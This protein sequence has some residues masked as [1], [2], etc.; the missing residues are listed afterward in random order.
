MKNLLP[1]PK[2]DFARMGCT[3]SAAAVVAAD[4]CPEGLGLLAEMFARKGPR[5]LGGSARMEY[6]FEDAERTADEGQNQRLEFFGRLAAGV[7]HDFNNLLTI[8]LGAGDVLSA[9]IGQ[10]DPRNLFVK[11]VQQAARKGASL[12]RQLK[13][14]SKNQPPRLERLDLNDVLEKTSDL[15]RNLLSPGIG[16]E[17]ELDGDLGSIDADPC[18]IEQVLMNL[19]LNARDAMPMGGTLRLS[20]ANLDWQPELH[21]AMPAGS[22]VVLT[23]SDNGTGMDKATLSRLFEPFFT[24]K[25]PSRGTGLGLVN[26]QSILKTIGGHIAVSSRVR[27]GTTFTLFFPR[28]R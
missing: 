9:Q 6:I 23:V 28:S 11:Q 20:T 15:L 21:A 3:S 4:A 1:T 13:A 5:P 26:V 16:L 14:L 7:V 17:M 10:D 18:Q 8:I 22:Y 12:I 25:G 19:V 2:T 24:T 27:Q